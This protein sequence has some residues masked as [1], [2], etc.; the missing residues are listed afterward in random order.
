MKKMLISVLSI[1]FSLPTLAGLYECTSPDAKPVLKSEVTKYI[2]L[3]TSS[4]FFMPYYKEPTINPDGKVPFLIYYAIDTEEPFM[5]YSVKYELAELRLACEKSDKVNFAAIINSKF[6][7]W[8]TIQICKNKKFEEIDLREFPVLFKSLEAKRHYIWDGDH[9]KSDAGPMSFLVRF[10]KENNKVFYEYPLAHPDFVHDLIS[11]VMTEESLFPKNK[12]IPFLNLKSHGSKKHVLS[13]L[14]PCQVQAKTQS[15]KAIIDK[16]LTDM[17]KFALDA[18]S[19]YQHIEVAKEALNKLSLGANV[20]AAAHDT[21]LGEYSLGEYSLGEY[22]LGD[23]MAGLGANE[24]LGAEFSFGT[25]HTALS[26]VLYRLF[27]DQDNNFLGFAMLESCDTNR[28][29]NF[30]HEHLEFVLGIYSA[31][32]SLWY[33]NL[34]WWSLLEKADGSSLELIKLL[35]NQTKKIPNIVVK[36]L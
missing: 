26:S 11:F 4:P 35:E 15:Q 33:R 21:H 6:A 10:Q 16:V 31:K 14:H 29:V 5:Q 25:Y 3:E 1:L 28:N 20:A 32:H 23:V 7:S 36:D 24:G 22:S 17:D 2:S 30:H 27:N 8:S 34:N 12:Y 19:Y 9:S 13:G 18:Q